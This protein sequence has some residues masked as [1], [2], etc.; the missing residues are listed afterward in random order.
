[1]QPV[2][3]GGSDDKS[4]NIREI[5]N[6]LENV[7]QLSLLNRH[8]IANVQNNAELNSSSYLSSFFSIL[9]SLI[10]S[11]PASLSALRHIL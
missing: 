3:C 6:R 10:H 9:G 8:N 1:M 5:Y 7:R 2:N 4:G 11:K